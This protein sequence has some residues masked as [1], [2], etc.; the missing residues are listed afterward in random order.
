MKIVALL[1]MKHCST[2]VPGKNYRLFNDKP[3]F[4]WILESIQRCKSIDEIVVDTDSDVIK[5]HLKDKA[6]TVLDRPEHL[7]PDC[8]MNDVL[9]HDVTHVPADLYI[10]VHA[11]S[12][13]LSSETIQ[14]AIDEFISKK[15]EHDSLFTVNAWK[16]RLYDSLCRPINH[17]H[18]ILLRTQDLPVVYE[19]NSCLY[20]FTAETFRCDRTRIGRRPIMFPLSRVEAV[21]IDTEDDFFLAECMCKRQMSEELKHNVSLSVIGT[22]STK[23]LLTCP[24]MIR[25][26]ERYESVINALNLSV[27]YYPN[28]SQTLTEET[29]IKLVPQFTGWII[30]DDPATEGV[31]TAGRNGQLRTAV[32]WG[33]G[34]DN[35]DF[36]ACKKLSISVTNTP[37][38]FG[39]EVSDV[40][41]GFMLCLTR[42]L[43]HTHCEI[44]KGLWTKPTGMSLTNKK[45]C[46]V[47]FGDIGRSIARKLLAFNMHVHVSD[48]SFSRGTNGTI[49][50]K[51]SN[52]R[53][54]PNL[55]DV[56]ITS[57]GDAANECD[58]LIVGCALNASTNGL[59]NASVLNMCKRGVILINVSRGKVINEPDVIALLK[60]Q[61]IH[62]VGFDVFETEPLDATNKL[63]EFPQNIFGSHNSSNTVEAVDAVSHTALHT[64]KDFLTAGNAYWEGIN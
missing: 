34:V 60:T 37:N 13:L 24:P 47:G 42:Q 3:L 4:L 15:H 46:L 59:I 21:D 29:L 61:H 2:R 50:C 25:Q 36:A 55:Y 35:V 43:H 12:P 56:N 1:P 6:V 62:A 14:R 23:L 31:L 28:C 9:I 53:I 49:Q 26:I 64:I 38:V 30:G 33:V 48:P 51:D 8:S 63:R 41:I 11:T 54:D 40:A 27:H 58:I 18:N 7:R 5:Q 32:K 39:E 45:V 16:T 52:V 19:E 44:Q 17:N 22:G 57:L 20:I 10:Q